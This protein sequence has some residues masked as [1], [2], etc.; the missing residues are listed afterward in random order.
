[1]A[2][3]DY[4]RA[5]G[6]QSYIRTNWDAFKKA[7]N[8][9]RAH[10]GNDGIYSNTEGTGWVE[11]WPGG[12][13]QEETYLASLDFEAQQAMADLAESMGDNLLA[14]EAETTR[15][16]DSRQ[17]SKHFLRQTGRLLCL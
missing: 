1:M 5:S 17:N 11:S 12:M 4:A 8:F 16:I 9:M 15:E 6:D 2:A 10:E 3:R 7:Y 14:R 13:P